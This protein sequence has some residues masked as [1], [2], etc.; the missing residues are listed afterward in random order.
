[1]PPAAVRADARALPLP[2]DSIDLVITS[3]PYFGLRSY[4]DHGRPVPGQLGAVRG[5]RHARRRLPTND[6]RPAMRVAPHSRTTRDWP[7]HGSTCASNHS[8]RM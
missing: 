4:T 2:D 6:R 7:I 1:V 8:A 5:R 3:P